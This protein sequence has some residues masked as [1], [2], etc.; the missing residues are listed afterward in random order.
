VSS[1]PRRIIE[2][3]LDL[4]M[5]LTRAR[6]GAVLACREGRISLVAS[7]GLDQNVLNNIQRV[8]SSC[9]RSLVARTPL[10]S[11]GPDAFLALP[12]LEKSELVGMLYVDTP[13]PAFRLP[14]E[15]L[16]TFSG[17]FGRGLR[18]LAAPSASQRR[19]WAIELDHAAPD[20]LER[21]R[22][23]LL[24]TRNEWNI[25]RVARILNVTRMTV[26]NRLVRFNIPRER[27]SKTQRRVR[28]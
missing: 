4:V 23:L 5:V 19:D 15:H 3:A 25:S 21:E 6:R 10:Y 11:E 24:L 28:V 9:Q 7:R 22:L 20:D 2:N 8:W 12:C 26:Y 17:I 13:E 16:A 18:A 27:V 14:P 1:N